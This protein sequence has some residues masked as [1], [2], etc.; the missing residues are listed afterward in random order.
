MR[1]NLNATFRDI[2]HLV[3]A[4]SNDGVKTPSESMFK[5]ILASINPFLPN[6]VQ[7]KD[8]VKHSIPE[9]ELRTQEE[10]AGYARMKWQLPELMAPELEP[11][12]PKNITGDDKL[13][14]SVKTPTVIE[15]KR[16]K[17][18]V[19]FTMLHRNERVQEVRK[20]VELEGKERGID[21]SLGMSI[22]AAESSFNVNAISSDGHA[23]KGLMQLLDSTGLDI[24]QRLGLQQDY[25]P[26]DPKQNVKLGLGYLRYL[27]D[28]FGK[29]TTLPND[30]NTY[31][32]ANSSSLEKLAVAAFNAGEGR[33]AAAQARAKSDGRDPSEYDQIQSY[34]PES[35]QEYVRRVLGL[36]PQ[37]G[38]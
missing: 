15:V 30:L 4:P 25:N 27:H 33:V 28:I 38:V 11:I 5:D 8:R 37:F 1:I 31:A 13:S 3:D 14:E 12:Q 9:L 22:I 7:S 26:F 2:R 17:Q 16:L 36:K 20:L 23:S 35:T 6:T 18:D 19:A 32:A 29:T 34:L 21:P 24:L 10:E